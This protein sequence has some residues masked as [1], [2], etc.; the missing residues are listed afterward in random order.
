MAQL[1]SAC[2]GSGDTAGSPGPSLA[3]HLYD[4]PIPGLISL[5]EKLPPKGSPKG[6]TLLVLD[7]QILQPHSSTVQ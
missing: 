7:S 5:Q 4:E 2:Y 1:R 6:S 3:A